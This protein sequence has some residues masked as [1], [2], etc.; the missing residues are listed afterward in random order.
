[1]THEQ[2][3]GIGGEPRGGPATD[4]RL[5]DARDIM[6]YSDVEG[7]LHQVHHFE[8][9]ELPSRP[10]QSFWAGEEGDETWGGDG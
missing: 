6:E 10:V 9:I 3:T 8:D 1:M 5:P 2:H 7:S 4:Q